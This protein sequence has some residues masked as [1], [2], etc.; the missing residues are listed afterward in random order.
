MSKCVCVCACDVCPPFSPLH[1]HTHTLQSADEYYICILNTRASDRILFHH[2][3]GVDVGDVDAKAASL[4][5]PVGEQLQL[6]DVMTL[7]DQV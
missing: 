3:G 7:I 2:E 4:D 6:A 1:A 5:V